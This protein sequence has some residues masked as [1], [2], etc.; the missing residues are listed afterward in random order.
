MP[1]II[2][3]IVL[4]FIFFLDRILPEII[5]SKSLSEDIFVCPNCG[6]QFY[7]KWYKLYYASFSIYAYNKALLKCPKCGIKDMCGRPH[8]Q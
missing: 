7:V 8:G 4:L 6:H 1:Y 3:V 2:I 5:R